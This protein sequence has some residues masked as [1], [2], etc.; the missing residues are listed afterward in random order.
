MCIRDRR[1]GNV[2][3]PSFAVGRTQ[4]ILYIVNRL[5]REGR[6][7]NLNVFIDSPLAKNATMIFLKHPEC[8]DKETLELIKRGEFIKG[9]P[10]LKFTE[11]PEESMAINKIRSGAVIISSSGMCEAGRIRH[12]LK[13]NLWR[14]E[15][16]II[17]VGF[18]AEGTLGRQ[19]V[20]GAKTIKLFSETIAVRAKI[21]TIGGL[22]AHA[23]KEGLLDWLAHFKIKPKK[24]FVVHGE[25]KISLNFA[26]A[27][28][29]RFLADAYVPKPLEEVML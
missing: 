11:A 25:E 2:I 17:F 20:E 3:I 13:H 6:L 18:Q 28:H 12:H 15:C 19:I 26:K 7:S 5:S 8:F 16:S 24:V 4:D 22:S 9:S 10:I 21:Y 1:G 27:V 29:E 14:E 23:D